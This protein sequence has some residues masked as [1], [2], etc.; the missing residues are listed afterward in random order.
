[1]SW[2]L[3]PLTP[4]FE[5]ALRDV[6][7]KRP[8]SRMAAAERLGRADDAQR[9]AALEGLR[10]LAKDGHAGVR[11][12]AMAA[13]GMLG[14]EAELELLERGLSDASPEVREFAAMAIAQVGGAR[15]LAVMRHALRHAA[16]EVR[17]QAVSAVLELDAERAVADLLPLLS[18]AD[19][20]V[21]AHVLSAL[22]S[23]EQAHLAGHFASALRDDA[24][25]VRLEAA[26]A[27]AALGDARGEATLIEAL[28]QRER[29]HEVAAALG[30]LGSERAREPLA[31][32]ALSL[33]VR[34]DVRACAG[35]ALARLGDER[36]VA[37]L[38]RVLLG[39]RSDARS[40]AVELSR[41]LQHEA[42][43][44]PLTRLARRPRGADLLGIIDALHA[45]GARFPAAR[46]ALDE[47]AAKA[48]EVGQAAQAALRSSSP[49]R[50][51]SSRDAGG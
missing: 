31:R 48:G 38:K 41:D 4:T 28:E 7:G 12:T 51:S 29:F 42:L 36:G 9:D 39:L 22:G 37:A 2:L 32:V 11:A 21:R 47:L 5:A 16:P 30:R 34:G 44:E 13:L 50:A 45:Y 26:L 6:R 35:A 15:G 46:A 40:Y 24:F 43:V 27:L 25:A 1:M 17:F 49:E 10:E 23:L 19:A 18:D 14:R 8:E 20:N 33:W 3:P